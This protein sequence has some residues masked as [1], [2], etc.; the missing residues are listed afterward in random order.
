MSLRDATEISSAAR[1]MES[2][3]A[4]SARRRKE[5]PRSRPYF[6]RKFDGGGGIELGFSAI[7]DDDVLYLEFA[8]QRHELND[9]QW[10]MLYRSLI[11]SAKKCTD[12]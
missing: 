2:L 4:R 10:T 11:N 9:Q 3:R 1:V 7:G 12:L 6:Q 8:N 5:R